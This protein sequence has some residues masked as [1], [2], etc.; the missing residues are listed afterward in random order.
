MRLWIARWLW[1]VIAVSWL[2]DGAA[3]CAAKGYPTRHDLQVNDYARIIGQQELKQIRTILADIKQQSGI[4]ATVLTISSINDYAT[5]DQSIESFAKHLF[6]LWGIGD[7]A[8]N[9][10]MLLV[11]AVKDRKVRVELGKAYG[12]IYDARMKEV[13]DQRIVP[14][15]KRND[16]SLGILEGVEAIT[17]ALSR[18]PVSDSPQAPQRT[19]DSRGVFILLGLAFAVPIGVI[20]LI[21]LFSQGRSL[22]GGK[23]GPPASPPYLDGGSS[24]TGGGSCDGGGFSGGGGATGN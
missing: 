8:T 15:F 13:I 18:S 6:D 23:A 7:R 9:K 1:I 20:L 22:P 2:F 14:A 5:A 21:Y 3:V 19:G 11:V 24:F 17:T 16:Y 4:D 10:G 12:H